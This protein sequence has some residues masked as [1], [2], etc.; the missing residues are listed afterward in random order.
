M[1]QAGVFRRHFIS[2]NAFNYQSFS[3]LGAIVRLY[4]GGLGLHNK[5]RW[6]SFLYCCGFCSFKQEQV[7]SCFLSSAFNLQFVKKCGQ[8]G[9]AKGATEFFIR[10]FN[11]VLTEDSFSGRFL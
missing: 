8:R 1:I 2:Y 4:H 5:Q 6:M 10:C 7:R 3:Q 11:E 9:G